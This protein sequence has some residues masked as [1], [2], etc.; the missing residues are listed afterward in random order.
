MLSEV[1]ALVIYI[2]TEPSGPPQGFEILAG[3]TT[4]TFTWDLPLPADRNGRITSY[5]I[6]CSGSL[7][8]SPATSPYTAT[9]L[10][11]NTSYTCSIYASNAQGD[12]P[13]VQITVSTLEAGELVSVCACASVYVQ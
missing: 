6:Q 9:G 7:T 3:S 12:G 8:F 4:L 10:T 11:A 2:L 13:T 5:T 1:T